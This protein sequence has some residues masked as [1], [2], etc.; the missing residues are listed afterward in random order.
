M[1]ERIVG[2][3][4]TAEGGLFP[5]LLPDTWY[6]AKGLLLPAPLAVPR[7]HG[8]PA[9]LGLLDHLLQQ[10]GLADTRLAVK[11]T[12]DP[13]YLF[14]LVPSW[15]SPA[16]PRSAAGMAC[17]VRPLQTCPRGITEQHRGWQ[18]RNSAP[19]HCWSAAD[20]ARG[21]SARARTSSWR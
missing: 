4:Y 15:H 11:K 2:M 21:S 12:Y 20:A 16:M 19:D 18:C 17:C 13:T 9:G 6:I 3:Y 10:A 5:R 7:Q 8:P 1:S 14:R